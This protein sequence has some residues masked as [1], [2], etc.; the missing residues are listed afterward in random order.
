MNA[1]D[2]TPHFFFFS[3]EGT[4]VLI[5]IF[6]ITAMSFVP[7]SF[8]LYLVNERTIRA[9]H[10]QSMA[11]LQ[12]AIYWAANFAWDITNYSVCCEIPFHV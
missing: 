7:A 8:V 3:L 6:I 11:G 1:K 12:P 2:F 10:L 9:K 5:A 4:D